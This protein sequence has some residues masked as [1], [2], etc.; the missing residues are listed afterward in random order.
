MLISISVDNRID[1]DRSL[2]EII[3]KY[4]LCGFW[5]KQELILFWVPYMENEGTIVIMYNIEF[6]IMSLYWNSE[7]KRIKTRKKMRSVYDKINIFFLYISVG[8]FIAIVCWRHGV[9]WN[10]LLAQQF[11]WLTFM[12]FGFV[13]HFFFFHHMDTLLRNC[14][15]F[16]SIVIKSNTLTLLWMGQLSLNFFFLLLWNLFLNIA[17][18]VYFHPEKST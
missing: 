10:E 13:Y 17:R 4:E 9:M 8:C 7:Q 18:S 5:P 6:I 1:K 3:L 15:C 16:W 11:K 2:T 12:R 14:Y